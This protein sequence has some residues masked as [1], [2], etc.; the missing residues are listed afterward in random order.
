MRALVLKLPFAMVENITTVYI[1]SE[2]LT[3]T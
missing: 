3:A 1:P 2:S